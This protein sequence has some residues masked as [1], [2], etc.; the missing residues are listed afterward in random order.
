[1][2]AFLTSS[3]E[4]RI[5]IRL[6]ISLSRTVIDFIATLYLSNLLEYEI[7]YNKRAKK[8]MLVVFGRL[9]L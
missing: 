2:F 7:I 8:E 4:L 6:F 1:M 9:A 3:Y 5:G